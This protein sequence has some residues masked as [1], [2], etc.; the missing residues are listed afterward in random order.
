MTFKERLEFESRNFQRN[1]DIFDIRLDSIEYDLFFTFCQMKQW[2]ITTDVNG[3]IC[4]ECGDLFQNLIYNK[5]QTEFFCLQCY[6]EKYLG[7]F[8]PEDYNKG[9]RTNN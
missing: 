1:K 7:I 5:E 2:R 4:D 9:K 8:H 3:L 6:L